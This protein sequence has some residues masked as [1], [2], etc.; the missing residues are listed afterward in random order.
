MGRECGPGRDCARGTE[1]PQ[2]PWGGC[3]R[4][5]RGQK[6]SSAGGTPPEAS[7]DSRWVCLLRGPQTV[8]LRSP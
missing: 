1:R 2:T 3:H 5:S 7:Q 4:R 8:S 6:E